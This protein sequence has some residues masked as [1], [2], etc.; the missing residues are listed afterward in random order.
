[1]FSAAIIL[2]LFEQIT[3][4]NPIIALEKALLPATAPTG[5][6]WE[7]QQVRF[8]GVFRAQAFMSISIT[9]GAYCVMFFLFYFFFTNK[10]PLYNYFHKVKNKVKE[11]HLR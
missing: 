4:Y 6:I 1:M 5:L 3:H 7:S 8:G 11:M 2:S 10:Y 9:Y